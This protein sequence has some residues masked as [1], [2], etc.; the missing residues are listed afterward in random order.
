ML[1]PALLAVL[2]A[3]PAS[4]SSA[5]VRPKSCLHPKSGSPPT[6]LDD[7]RACQ[8]RARADAVSAA[9]SKGAPL[10][11]AQL[12][13]L[14]D[15][16]RAE[17]R[18]FLSSPSIV[19]SG[20]PAPP[21]TAQSSA[22]SG[23]LGGATAADLGRVDLNSAAAIKGLQGRLQAAAGDGQNGVTPAMANDVRATLTQAQGGISPDMAA[24]LDGVQADG[25]KLTPAT[26][27][28]LQG[29]GKAAK[30]S[31]LD[32]NIDPNTEKQLLDG[33]F[34]KDQTDPNASPAGM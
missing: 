19:T 22:P 27:M 16:Q 20:P 3:L 17:A 29:A 5:S 11:D 28:K 18:K 13:K 25:G 2:A 34:S 30:D 7:L 6:S 24:L 8:D 10:T 15:F 26:M 33:D 21:E 31:G 4:A 12:D 32:L 23:K 14:D 9:A 1:L